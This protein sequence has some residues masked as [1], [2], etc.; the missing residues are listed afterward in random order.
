MNKKDFAIIMSVLL[1]EMRIENL[2]QTGVA[3]KEQYISNEYATKI[4]NNEDHNAAIVE[5][6]RLS[7]LEEVTKNPNK[8]KKDSEGKYLY[9]KDA[10]HHAYLIDDYIGEQYLKDYPEYINVLV[11]DKCGSDNV[12]SKAWVNP[13]KNNEF[14]DTISKEEE[15][16]WCNDCDQYVSLSNKKVN[17]GAKVIGYQVVSMVDVDIHPSM[18]TCYSVYN[19][20]KA[21]EMVNDRNIDG[22]W[23]LLTIWDDD[24]KKP[25]LMSKE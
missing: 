9:S 10:Y 22:E 18:D 3:Y 1:F 13:N 4:L 14:V 15:D 12:Q 6:I 19:L 5:R 23:E 20:D 24:I 8:Y 11:C 25:I 2:T 7:V 21:N 17:Q 16:N